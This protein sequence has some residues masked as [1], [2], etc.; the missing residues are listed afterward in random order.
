[1]AENKMREIKIEKVTLNVGCGGDAEKIERAKILL[2]MLSGKKTVV[3]LSKRRS[4][5]GVSKGKPIGVMV[6]LR[7]KA[8]EDFLKRALYALENK[9]SSSHFSNEG[10]FSFGIKEYIDIQGVKYSHQIGMLGLDV[11]VS[12]KRAGF[13]IKYRK[14]Q[15]RKIPA[16]QKINKE[17][18]MNWLREKY[19]VD[20]V[21]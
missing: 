7:G 11:C 19:G 15:K 20:I 14:R 21:E 9:L 13:R 17:E 6:V 16:K 5:F 18:A 10:G 1:M 4:T 8:A 12:L 2:E 3:T